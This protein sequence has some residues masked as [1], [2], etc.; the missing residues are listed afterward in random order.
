MLKSLKDFI[1]NRKDRGENWP[2]RGLVYQW[3]FKNFHN[4][5]DICLRL[6]GTKI[7]IDENAFEAWLKTACVPVKN[8]QKRTKKKKVIRKSENK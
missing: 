2:T 8:D 1:Q 7:L 5:N 3:K 6:L 4:F